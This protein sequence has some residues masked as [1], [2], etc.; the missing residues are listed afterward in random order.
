MSRAALPRTGLRAAA[1]GL[2][3]NAFLAGAKLLAGILGH[4]YALIADATESAADMASSLVVYAGLRIAATPPDEN[5]PYGHGKA[6]PLSALVVSLGLVGAAAGIA[7]QSLGEIHAPHHRPAPFTLIVLVGVVL[8]KETLFRIAFRAGEEIESTA[9][10]SDAWHHR[11]DALTS[12]AA[13]LGISIA[14]LG[15]PRFARADDWAALFASLVILVNAFRLLRPALA[16]VMDAAPSPALKAD[17]RRAASAVP[18]VTGLDKCLVRK[19]GLDLYVDLHI[20]VDGDLRVREGHD[21]A[22]RVKEAVQAAN[23]R[24]FDVLVHVEPAGESEKPGIA[25][26]TAPAA[27]GRAAGDSHS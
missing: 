4:S 23:P 17:V 14:L 15:G 6:E 19:M 7:F 21:I 16:E 11:T 10:R 18:G 20:Y 12:A 9:L 22:H 1:L 24:V 2:T 26:R 27:I 13:F 8:M 5:H 25:G 3:V